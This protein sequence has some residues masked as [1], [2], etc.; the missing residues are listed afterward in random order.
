MDLLGR[1]HHEPFVQ[2]LFVPP[3]PRI[4]GAVLNGLGGTQEDQPALWSGSYHTCEYW[5][6]MVCHTMWLAATLKEFYRRA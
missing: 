6:P 2:N 3:T 5:T 4:R 1:N